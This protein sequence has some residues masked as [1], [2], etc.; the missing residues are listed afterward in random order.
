M[1]RGSKGQQPTGAKLVAHGI[2]VNVGWGPHTTRKRIDDTL[3]HMSSN[4]SF[5]HSSHSLNKNFTH[6]SSPR[7]SEREW[8]RERW[9][10]E[11][12]RLKRKNE[13]RRRIRSKKG[14][15][16]RPE[17]LLSKSL[18]LFARSIPLLP[19]YHIISFAPWYYHHHDL[20][21]LFF[22]HFFCYVPI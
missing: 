16:L 17:P 6:F 2:V 5:F 21:G 9:L 18:V 19:T 7:A 12:R 22:L 10:G 14:L 11:S 20:L 15:N 13:M 1:P 3:T 8:D 4:F